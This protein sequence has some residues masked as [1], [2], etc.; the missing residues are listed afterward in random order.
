MHFQS[1]I[2]QKAVGRTKDCKPTGNRAAEDVAA[3][4]SICMLCLLARKHDLVTNAAKC[5]P[6][7]KV[8]CA[9]G[10]P[11]GGNSLSIGANAA[12]RIKNGP[13]YTFYITSTRA[14]THSHTE[15]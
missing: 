12:K 11:T 1:V 7:R 13:K 9:K 3:S 8:A 5:A 4:A 2:Q 10:V 15:E 6:K 14:R